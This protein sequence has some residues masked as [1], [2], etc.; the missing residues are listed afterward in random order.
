MKIN[1]LKING[2]GNLKNKEIELKNGIN[3]IC[4]K[5][6]TGKSTLLKFI[7]C[8]LYGASKNKNGKEIS[9]LEKYTPWDNPEYSG[10]LSYELDNKEK[11]EIFREFGKKTL[12]IYNEKTEEISKNF[13]SNKTK[14][15][16]FFYEQTKIDEEL[17]KNTVMVE[18][19]ESRLD[20]LSQNVLIQKITNLI[21]TGSDNISYKKAID[22]LNKKIQ[23]EVGT[24]RTIGRP[25]NLIEEKIKELENKKTNIE[26]NKEEIKLIEKEKIELDLEIENLENKNKLLKDIKAKKEKEKI[27]VEKIKTNEQLKNEADEK[28]NRLKSEIK[29]EKIETNKNTL[30]Y[31]FIALIIL[32]ATIGIILK[33]I[34]VFIGVAVEIVA[35]LV[36]FIF[37]KNKKKKEIEKTKE[38]NS[39]INSQIEILEENK[40]EIENKIK[41]ILEE[42]NEE[43][44]KD[45]KEIENIYLG[46]IESYLIENY[47]NKNYEEILFEINSEENKLS[48]LKIKQNTLLLEKDRIENSDNNLEEI[49]KNIEEAKEEK[50][51]IL[52]LENSIKIAKDA[53]EKA[54]EKAKQNITP[55]FI[56]SLKEG[57][58]KIS[59]GKYKNISFNDETGLKIEIKNGDYIP[60]EDLSM[61][62]I[63]Q[64]YLSLRINAINQIVEEK[65]P[66]ILDEVFAYYDDE[67]ME[68]ILNYLSEEFKDFQIIIF[69]CSNREE[70]ILE[71]IKVKFN[72][73]QM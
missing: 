58:N 41:N 4:G 72:K 49:E 36:Y 7:Y 29:E 67:R 33:N 46:K 30:N 13:S 1:S 27:N 24:N 44:D 56:N 68:N 73:I 39:K 6:E 8:M 37:G 16:E 47:F 3:L 70:E 31:I 12:K 66:I 50:E 42:I 51:K 19:G 28:I 18:Q 60:V 61:G 48:N 53:L 25:K 5:N 38:E 20:K 65:L 2:F 23:E 64:M 59:N 21:S 34:F 43:K 54:Y 26:K 9:D 22:K 11:F 55:E 14:G 40:N 62:T 69:T 52:S 57:I 35:F 15:I 71:K 17:F 10:K 63:D 45:K 32:T